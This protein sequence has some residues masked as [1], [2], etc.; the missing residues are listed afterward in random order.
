MSL[1]ARG[2]VVL[3]TR[4]GAASGSMA[5]AAALARTASES[6]RA[7]LLIDVG[8]GRDPRSTLIATEGARALEERLAAHL[9]DAAVA[10]RGW[11]CVLKAPPE[12]TAFETL[13]A[14]LPLVREPAAV[15]HLAPAQLRAALT[16][17]GIQPTAA[18]LCAKLANDRALT[19]LAI[20]DLMDAGLRTA[21]LKR[22]LGRLSALSAQLGVLPPSAPVLPARLC[23]RLLATDD[24]R[25]PK[26]Y[27]G[28]DESRDEREEIWAR[29]QRP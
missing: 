26:R 29:G 19:A 28:G 11:I 3:V 24:K 8:E 27:P 25:L 13:A 7:A 18:L 17:P 20:R 6:D 21:V 1:G 16:A 5:A 2:P 4:V 22:P 23:E 14:A 10:S 15:I 9:P 12:P